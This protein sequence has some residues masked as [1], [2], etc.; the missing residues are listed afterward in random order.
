MTDFFR[1]SPNS[2]LETGAIE[3]NPLA[4]FSRDV[5]QGVGSDSEDP[6]AV[7]DAILGRTANAQAPVWPDPPPE[8]DPEP[9]D[10]QTDPACEVRVEVGPPDLFDQAGILFRQ[11]A[12]DLVEDPLFVIAEGH[13]CL[14][15]PGGPPIDYRFASANTG[16]HRPNGRLG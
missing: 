2:A 1:E 7:D 13:A 16:R 14:P 8:A 9:E 3:G 11:P 15:S 10:G 5:R 12:F 4:L 6:A